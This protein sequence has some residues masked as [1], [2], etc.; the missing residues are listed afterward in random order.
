MIHFLQPTATKL[1]GL[2]RLV[3]LEVLGQGSFLDYPKV[4]FNPGVSLLGK[5]T[6]LGFKSTLG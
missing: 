2:E 4:D 1:S 5:S 3:P 6:T